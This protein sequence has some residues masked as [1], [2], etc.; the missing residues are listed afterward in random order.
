ME[1]V[2]VIAKLFDKIGPACQILL[3]TVNGFWQEKKKEKSGFPRENFNVIPTAL[4]I[5]T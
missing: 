1:Y 2:Y 5:K 4:V 3:D